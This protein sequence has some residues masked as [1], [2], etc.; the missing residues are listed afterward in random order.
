[1]KK[2]SCSILVV[3]IM[4]SMTMVSYAGVNTSQEIDVEDIR[5]EMD[6][7]VLELLKDIPVYI[8]YTYDR[9]ENI[10]EEANSFIKGKMLQ[11]DSSEE[12]NE[13]YDI[14]EL[15][16]EEKEKVIFEPLFYDIINNVKKCIEEGV[17]VTYLN[18]FLPS[19][20]DYSIEN[21]SMRA[22]SNANSK[23][24]WESTCSS[25]GTYNGYKFLYLESSMGVESS[26]VKPGNLTSSMKWSEVAKAS[27]E[28]L[29]DRYVKDSYYDAIKAASGLMSTVFKAYQAPISISYSSSTGYVKAKISGDL[30]H[31]TVL[32]RDDLNRIKGYAYY[33][34]GSTE[35]LVTAM[36][37]EA[38][39]PYKK[40]S[41]G[42]YQYEYPTY[43]SSKQSCNT[44]GYYGNTTLYK[45]IIKYY[46]NTGGYFT[47]DEDLKVGSLVAKLLK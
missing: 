10:Q 39:Y 27:L 45:S 9:E 37:I 13:Q 6:N 28:L 44:P 4:V 40:N 26:W 29:V 31:R 21:T 38:K 8:T 30:Y 17:E 34:W 5:S 3:M 7:D 11:Q 12:N 32:I 36:R 15:T 46:T 25:L 42:T 16:D 24:Y 1:M 47:H 19:T 18:I 35:K 14:V 20:S 2:V 43:T 33:Q 22:S 41:S 23:A